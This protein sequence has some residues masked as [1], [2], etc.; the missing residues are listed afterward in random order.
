M[1]NPAL[2]RIK[3]VLLTLCLPALAQLSSKQDA[4]AHDFSKEGAVGEH[5][6]TKV[7]FQSDGSYTREQKTRVR[8]QTDAGV[9]EYAVLRPPYQTS[10]ERIEVL[11]VRVTKP[12]GSVVISPLDSIQDAPSQIPGA[13]EFANLHEKHVPVK[14][15]EPGDVL[16]YSIRW[17]VETPLAA[18]QFW[19]GHSFLKSAIILAEQLEMS[20][21]SDRDVKLKSQN[22]QPTIREENGRR[23][24]TWKTSNL[25]SQN[26]EKQREAQSYDAIRGQLRGADVLISSFRSW[27]EVGR[28]Y[29]SLQKEKIQPSPDVKAKAEEL[30]RGLRDDDAKLRAI[31]NYVSLR[32]HYVGIALGVG[33]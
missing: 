24:Y 15:L 27:E 20:V 29:E 18:G 11:D 6:E 2:L 10:L 32:Y 5:L 17:Q 8:I 30:T 13:A 25:E 3:L 4:A 19:Y 9:Q 21:P 7:V 31:Y 26:I 33:R 1:S 14:G 28:W 16:E 12:N 23:V 22:V